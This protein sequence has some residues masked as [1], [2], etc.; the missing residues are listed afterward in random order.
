M[1]LSYVA[2]SGKDV[3]DMVA[4]IEEVVQGK[5]NVLVSISC[6][7]VA[8]LAQNPDVAPDKLQEVV[9]SLSEQLSATLFDASPGM[10]N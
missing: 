6:L 5:S 4:E 10:V 8:T 9:K 1:A 2:A 7:V 3:A